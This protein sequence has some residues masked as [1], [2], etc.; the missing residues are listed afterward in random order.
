MKSCVSIYNLNFYYGKNQILKDIN[1]NIKNKNFISIIGANG[2]GKTT[3]LK[4]ITRINSVTK[5]KVFL[6]E[7]DINNYS[8]RDLAKLLSYVPQTINTDFD[9]SV[10]D[11]VLL[12]RN[13]YLNFSKSLKYTDYE[14]VY[15]ILKQ[16]ECIHL[17]NKSINK[18]S[19]GERQ[20]IFIAKALAQ[21]TPI[22]LLDEP[23]SSLDL[24]NQIEILDILKQLSKKNKIIITVLH[25]LN[26]ALM[27]S[28]YIIML[29]SGKI[30][31]T[32]NPDILL[33][34]KN[35]KSCFN[36]DVNI[37]QDKFIHPK[38]NHV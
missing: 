30:F 23:V 1:L 20:K 3:L 14:V 17:T 38:T 7:N 15:D 22:L 34:N 9:F 4:V 37:I 26:L 10:L 16:V 12:G 27:Y 35:I 13:P 31:K 19:G 36:I 18:L 32:G 28:D 5:G 21:D 29:K 33:N 25:D 24:Y 2:S 11:I 6:F 8:Y